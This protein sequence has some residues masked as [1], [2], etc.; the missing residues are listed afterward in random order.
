MGMMNAG[1]GVRFPLLLTLACRI[2][3]TGIACFLLKLLVWPASMIYPYITALGAN[4]NAFHAE[5]ERDGSVPRIKLLVGTFL[6]ASIYYFVPGKY[7]RSLGISNTEVETDGIVVHRI[8][9]DITFILFM[10]LLDCSR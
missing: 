8:Y 3:G 5:D 4:L 6:V 9:H 2:G 7:M 10:G 1:L